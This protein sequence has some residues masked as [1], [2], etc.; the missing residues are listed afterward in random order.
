VKMLL[1][2]LGFLLC[3]SVALTLQMRLKFMTICLSFIPC[4]EG[5]GEGELFLVFEHTH[6][7][8][9]QQQS[10]DKQNEK[11]AS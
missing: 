8:S 6:T 11:T 1:R 5:E 9:Q 10:L 4:N 2:R 7:Q 3:C